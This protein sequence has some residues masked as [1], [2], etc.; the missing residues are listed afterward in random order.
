[1]NLINIKLSKK[2]KIILIIVPA[3]AGLVIAGG[4]AATSK[5]MGSDPAA[6]G[7]C[8]VMRTYVQSYFSSTHLDNV[9]AGNKPAI[10]CEDCHRQTILQKS[11]ELVSFLTGTD[12][13][14]GRNVVT[15]PACL[16]CHRITSINEGVQ[17]K[18]GFAA[19]PEGSYHLNADI[20]KACRDPRA[21]LVQC[22]DCHKVHK[23][24]ENYCSTCHDRPYVTPGD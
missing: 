14:S 9:H 18:P 11:S 10:K 3:A 12:S 6:C 22:Q 7:K 1:M 15:N 24:P 20:A 4:A 19:D 21:E 17:N 16:G 5:Y 8:H 23:A 13:V 2:W